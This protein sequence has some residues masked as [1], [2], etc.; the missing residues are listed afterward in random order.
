M[1]HKINRYW[2]V[3]INGGRWAIAKNRLK[4]GGGVLQI[5]VE[6]TNGRCISASAVVRSRA[7]VV[8]KGLVKGQGLTQCLTFSH[9]PPRTRGVVYSIGSRGQ[10]R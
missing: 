3:I 4:L 1:L 10:R 7:S 6:G 5:T 9:A 2:R 8:N